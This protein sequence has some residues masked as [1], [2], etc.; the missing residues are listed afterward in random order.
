MSLSQLHNTTVLV[1]VNYDLP[2]LQATDR[3]QDSKAT[4]D[5]LLSQNNKVVLLTHWGR[6]EEKDEQ[7]N[8]RI[9]LPVLEQVL[10]RG[11]QFVDQFESYTTAKH[12]IL[13]SQNK[14][15]LLQNTRYETDEK[16][17]DSALRLVIAGN[18]AGLGKAF[19]DEAFAVSHRTEATNYDIKKILPSCTGLSYDTEIKSLDKLKSNSTSPLVFVMGGS[20]LETKLPVITKLIDKVDQFLLGGTLCFTFL[21]ATGDIDNYSNPDIKFGK[22]VVESDFLETARD[23]LRNYPDKF[24]LPVD[25]VFADSQGQVTDDNTQFPYDIGDQTLANF[26]QKLTKAKTIFWNGTMGYYEKSPFDQGTDKLARIIL[27]TKAWKAVG[28]GDTVEAIE[29]YKTSFD[30]IS[31]GGG[32]TL[33]Y[34]SK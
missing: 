33:E 15:F 12:T 17:T 31:M 25:F 32:A 16:S 19:V 18:Y 8:C 24:V 22:G 3:I 4:I 6:P 13:D 5:L 7:L 11:I 29:N 21:Q 28:G 14:L 1:R 30:Y 9:L 20:K 2:N 27:E 34:L 26:A 10:G 23:L